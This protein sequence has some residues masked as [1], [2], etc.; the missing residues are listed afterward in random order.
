MEDG[1]YQLRFFEVWKPIKSFQGKYEISNMGRVASVDRILSN[2]RHQRGRI[3]KTRIDKYGYEVV[4]LRDGDKV[5]NLFVHRLV[6]THFLPNWDRL[7]QVNH[8]DE[9]K[10]NNKVINLEWCDGFYNQNYGT[11]NIRRSKSLTNEKVKSKPVSQFSL[12][13]TLIKTYP[14]IA[15]AKRQ[16][17]I[18]NI[19]KCCRGS[20]R[21]STSG[22]FKWKY[23]QIIK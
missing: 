18:G 2:G 14:S 21:Y 5:F 22:G 7:P 13:G 15:E 3:L 20:S 19:S 8:R 23:V 12:D 4:N 9:N 11:I 17:G 16:T 10:T 6:A 1:S